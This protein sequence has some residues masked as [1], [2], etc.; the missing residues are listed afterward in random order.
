MSKTSRDVIPHK[1]TLWAP[2]Q[3]CKGFVKLKINNVNDVNDLNDVN[4][5]NDVIE[6]NQRKLESGVSKLSSH[7][8]AYKK[9]ILLT[10]RVLE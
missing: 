5:V 2:P 7:N 9:V 3:P 8:L 1:K 10:Q 6:F 4:D